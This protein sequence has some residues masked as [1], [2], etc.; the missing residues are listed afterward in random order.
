VVVFG[1]VV[2]L[3]VDRAVLA[4]DGLPDPR[5]LAPLSR[6]GR[7]QW[8]LLGEVIDLPRIRFTDWEQGTRSGD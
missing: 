7:A 2:H 4:D 1:E 6:L 8:G 5:K 3:A